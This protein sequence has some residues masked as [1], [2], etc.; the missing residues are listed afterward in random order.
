MN[1]DLLAEMYEMEGDYWWHKSKRECVISLLK[2]FNKLDSKILDV[3]CGTG[4]L[5]KDLNHHTTKSYGLDSS[6]LSL[7]YSKKRGLKNISFFDIEKGPFKGSFD[8]ITA[9]DVIEHIQNDNQAMGNIA[10]SLKSHGFVVI[11]TPA[12]PFLWSYWDVLAGHYRRYDK[13]SLFRLLEDNGFEVCYF[14][15][16]DMVIFIPAIISRFIKSRLME[17]RALEFDSDFIKVS[18][19]VNKLLLFILK[20]EM[21]LAGLISLPF[22]LSCIVVAQRRY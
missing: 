16:T 2:R 3:G 4:Y 6:K 12:F 1:K 10:K 20:I 22:G 21:K 8:V 9:T 7:R 14:S 11:S 19:L 18:K 17:K 15:Y 13:D 5:L